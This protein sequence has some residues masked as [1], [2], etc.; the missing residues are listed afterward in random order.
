ML[1]SAASLLLLL[2]VGLL[3]CSSEEP[4]RTSEA[5]SPAASAEPSAA[6][7][8]VEPAT[9]TSTSAAQTA[10]NSPP[11]LL[12]GD[13][14]AEGWISLF[15]G[16]TLFGWQAHSKAD[17]QVKDGAISVAE[18]EPGLLCTTSPFADYVLKLE[19]RAEAQTNSGVFL[20]TEP[21]VSKDDVTT[22]C[23]EL[24]IAPSENSFP[25]GSFVG[26]QKAEGETLDGGWRTF[27]VTLQ[28][29]HATVKYNGRQVVDYT[30]PAPIARGLI[31]LQLNSGPVEFRNIK[32]KP[33]G[34]ENL[35]PGPKLTGWTSHGE[36]KFTLNEQQELQVTGG[37][38]H[39]ESEMVVGDFVLQLECI[40]HAEH[41]N[42]GLF[43][44]CIPGEAM[45]GYESQIHNGFKQGDRTQPVDHGTGGIF[46]R[47]P[48]RRVVADDKQ[49]FS[50]TIVAA[51][52]HV[53][54]WVNGYQ[55]TD[56]TDTRKPHANPRNGLRT[57]AGTLQI[58]GH[59]PTTD[60]SFR[61][62]RARAL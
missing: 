41:L 32:L 29:G 5:S 15:D 17:W 26:R 4:K 58:Q 28:G 19:F 37:K 7:L 24:N 13:E 35:L 30:D 49:W 14:I 61:K 44:R 53:A 39:L 60:L 59:D 56:W 18:G 52:P 11:T 33:L 54:V 34:L 47:V 25:T 62:L 36:S 20:R 43:Y 50:K 31:G 27:E 6:K 42:S 1:R 45:N 55:V 23:Y 3:S 21:V 38:G 12:T 10:A 57:E 46:R 8:V 22:K 2:V 9:E 51:G 40:T 16:H 48:A